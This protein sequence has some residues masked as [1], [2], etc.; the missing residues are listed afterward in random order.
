MSEILSVRQFTQHIKESLEKRFPFVWVSGEVT[1][2]AR[3][4]SGHV[5]FSLRDGE[6]LLNCVWFRGR[7]KDREAFDPL[8]GEVFEDGP[9]PCLARTMR[10]GD[11]IACA[12]A[13]T[14]YGPRGAYQLLVELAQETGQGDLLRQLERLKQE[15]ADK[16]WFA[17][18]R[19]RP[20]PDTPLRVA[21][22]TAPTGAAVR[23]FLRIA[24][25]RGT[26]AAIRIL[27]VPVQGTDAPPKLVRALQ[28][29]NA[30]NWADVVVIIRGGG[31]LEDLWAFNNP[32]LAEAIVNSRLPVLT[33]IGHEVDTSIADMV[34]DVRA[35]T[36]SHAAQ[37][38]W[39]E[40]EWFAQRLDSVALALTQSMTRRLAGL[41]GRLEHFK[42]GLDWLSPARR[43]DRATEQ[44][45]QLRRRLDA[46]MAHR[47]AAHH[48][49]LLD[50]NA[51]LVRSNPQR[52]MQDLFVDLIR[53][54][55]DLRAAA[56]R[57]PQRAEHRLEQLA[58]RLAGLDP[59]APLQRGY[60]L[61][62]SKDTILRRAADAAPGD[63][64]RV[65]LHDGEVAAT[66]TSIAMKDPSH[67]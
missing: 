4:G 46:A 32:A 2:V 3:P 64:L 58:A 34:A 45:A 37:I 35:A 19:K 15:L 23:D 13:V 59:H 38:L 26:G 67:A 39:R 5:Y 6:D 56:P 8:T 25:E 7:Q 14:V 60:A 24:A 18:E 31:S 48:N 57:V 66:V 54:E 10:D 51:Y 63:V 61:I 52:W 65:C 20:L 30:D 27:P 33:G 28:Q 50:F 1:N 9:K 62:R 49:K 21:L 53:L 43:V 11:T 22:I 36:P 40:R 17:Q 42:R 55:R 44:H 29:A 47:L 12:G 41:A 16:G